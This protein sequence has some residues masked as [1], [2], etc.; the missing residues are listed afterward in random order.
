[1]V[2][3]L[4]VDDNDTNLQI[5]EDLLASWGLP[6]DRAENAPQALRLLESARLANKPYGLAIIDYQMPLMHGGELAELI[7][8]SPN[9]E[10]LPIILLASLHASEIGPVRNLINDALTKPVRQKELHRVIERVLANPNGRKAASDP[11]ERRS[12]RSDV[13][14]GPRQSLAAPRI[15]VA[16]DNPINQVVMVEMLH[17]LGCDVDVVENGRL[18]LDAI[19]TNDYPIVLMDC[20][21]PE[22]D[23][24]EATR[25]LRA[26]GS[27]KARIPIIAVTAHAVV[28]ERERALAAGMSDYVAKPVTPTALANVLSKWLEPGTQEAPPSEVS[29]PKNV[30]VLTPQNRSQKVIEL[31]LRFAPAQIDSITAAIR[32]RDDSALRAASHKLKGSCMAIGAIAMARLCAAL[33]PCPERALDLAT[34]LH[35][36]FELVRV[37]LAEEFRETPTIRPPSKRKS[38]MRS[39]ERS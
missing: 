7:R 26:S 2:R 4:V 23:G 5:L 10:D 30:Q 31:F 24:Y 27:P 36:E 34:R 33:E 32:S 14:S 22:L 35:A 20:Q 11:V 28:G 17:E 37:S 29:P 3:T 9:L 1:V 8:S 19:L 16:E 15:L 12:N 38:A 39:S 6:V 13:E 25:R 21:M 18:A